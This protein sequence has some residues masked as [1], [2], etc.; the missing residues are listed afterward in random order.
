VISGLGVPRTGHGR[1]MRLF[2][3]TVAFDVTPAG[4]YGI[5]EAHH[6]HHH[7]HQQLTKPVETLEIQSGQNG[8]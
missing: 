6:H 8:V 7:H 3:M 1:V 2:S 5:S 4:R